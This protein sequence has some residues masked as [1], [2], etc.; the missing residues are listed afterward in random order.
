MQNLGPV[1]SELGCFAHV[2]S[3]NESRISHNARVCSEQSWHVLPQYDVARAEHPADHRRGEIRA[4]SAESY[5]RAVTRLPNKTRYDRHDILIEQR[6]QRGCRGG[7]RAVH[8]G[9]GITVR[10][11]GANDLYC[12]DKL[13]RDT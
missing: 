4:T 1:V 8:V 3:R 12:V 6:S 9:T 13:R 10:T 5:D 11:I 2:Q 7:S